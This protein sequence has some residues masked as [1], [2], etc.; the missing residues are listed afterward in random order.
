MYDEVFPQLDLL[1]S[2]LYRALRVQNL[3]AIMPAVNSLLAQTQVSARPAYASAP[4]ASV[5]PAD[6]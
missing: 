6:A 4:A 2:Q 5:Q 3:D 1:V